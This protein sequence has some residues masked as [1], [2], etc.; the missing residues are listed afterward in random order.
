M[1]YV[2]FVGDCNGRGLVFEF[3]L[4]HFKT[5]ATLANTKCKGLVL[6]RKKM[7]LANATAVGVVRLGMGLEYRKSVFEFPV[8]V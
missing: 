4:A 3:K 5:R 8:G 6:A 2:F 7:T 1:N